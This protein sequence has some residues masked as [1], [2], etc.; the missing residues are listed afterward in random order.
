MTQSSK[1]PLIVAVGFAS[2]VVTLIACTYVIDRSLTK[3]LRNSGNDDVVSALE[4]EGS[5]TRDAIKGVKPAE[6]DLVQPW[7]IPKS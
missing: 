4:S 1:L 7:I 3:I 2:V 5:K 6:P